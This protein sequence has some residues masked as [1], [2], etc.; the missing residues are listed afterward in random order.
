MHRAVQGAALRALGAREVVIGRFE[1]GESVG[2]ALA[3]AESVYHIGPNMHPDELAI[4]RRVAAA[5]RAAGVRR[6]VYHSVLHPQ[7]EEMPHHW[8]KLRVEEFLLTTDLRCTV[9]QP[10]AYMQNLLAYWPAIVGAGILSCSLCG[11]HAPGAG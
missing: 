6:F 7:T 8:Q 11:W 2:R 10:A 1:D 3:G 9:L 5:V 4:V